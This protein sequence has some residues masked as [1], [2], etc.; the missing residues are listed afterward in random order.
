MDTAALNDAAAIIAATA[1]F[2]AKPSRPDLAQD[3]VQHCARTLRL[4][5]VHLASLLPDQARMQ[6]QAAWMDGKPAAN[7]SYDLAGTPAADLARGAHHCIQSGAQRLFPTDLQLRLLGAQGYVGAPVATPA[8]QIVGVLVGTTRAPLR[9]PEVVLASL[10]IFAQ[11]AGAERA[12]REARRSLA[13]QQDRLRSVLQRLELILVGV[14]DKGRINLINRQ[15]CDLLG[16]SES[17]LIGQDWRDF[18]SP[19]PARRPERCGHQ[20]PDL[21]GSPTDRPDVSPAGSDLFVQSIHT[22]VRGA[23]LIAW[24]RDGLEDEAGRSVG[25]LYI[26]EDITERRSAPCKLTD[27]ALL[28]GALADSGPALIWAAD[29][30]KRCH[31]FN[32]VWLAFTGRTLEQERGFGWT[33]GVHPDDLER[34]VAAYSAAF[35]RREAF[36]LLYRLRRHDG[37]YR[38]LQ[39]DGCP[40]YDQTG[41]LIGYIG[42]CLDVTAAQEAREAS[43]SERRFQQAL[44]DHFPFMIWLKDKDGR[45]LAVNETFAKIAQAP[46]VSWMLGKTDLDIWPEPLAERYRADD[47][48][49]LASREKLQVEE[50]IIQPDGPQ[51]FETFKAPVANAD[52]TL[53]GTIGF[54]RNV[55][56]RKAAEERIRQ[57]AYFD[58]LTGLPNRRLLMDRLQHALVASNRSRSYG[59]LLMLDL[60]HFKALND[61]RGHDVGDRLLSEVAHRIKTTLREEDT[62]S[63]L[64]GDEYVVMLEDLGASET[65]AANEAELIADKVR[66]AINA[67][68][69]L[70]DS[71][72]LH[73][74]TSS[75]GLTLFRGAQDPVEVLLKQADVALYQAKDAGR[76]AVRFFNPAMQTA[77]ESRIA[78]EAELR[79]A[80]GGGELRLFYQPQ[81]NREG[82]CFGAEALLRWHRP[83]IGLVPPREFVPLA[84]ETGLILSIGRWVLETACAQLKTWSA[85]PRTTG[86]QLAINVSAR[87]FHQADFVAQVRDCIER[88]G[89]NPER[90]RLELTETTILGHADTVIARMHELKALGIGFSMDDFGNGYSSLSSLKRLP[91]DQLKIDQSFVRDLTTD[92]SDAAIVK[93]ILA[94]SQSLGL[95]TIAEGVETGEQKRFLE[96]HGCYAFQGH[97]FGRPVPIEEWTTE[98]GSLGQD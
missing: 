59:A 71:G 42:Y 75:I 24:R 1:A 21:T 13:Q 17:E 7:W 9:A 11:R 50:Q 31:Y 91:L 29:R 19:S 14:D 70:A 35:D 67:P 77:I 76:N 53:L 10:R 60:D 94:M 82:R 65:T 40:R 83:R 96:E 41:A 73:H 26:G 79:E 4:D 38:W 56:D 84:E 58:P 43:L 12:E 45:F 8:G 88:A 33:E 66:T 37:E 69:D 30:D 6:T 52:G 46:S 81:M 80:V 3:L 47:A 55:S 68:Y 74:C 72:R 87:Q 20:T 54:S 86:L 93:A 25:A 2:V 57:L 92:P 22:G 85:D 32:R 34:C 90:L 16:R 36:S 39:D 97:L 44:F 95:Q 61:T 62:V 15:G 18:F 23:R 48:R 64:G 51:W 49:V 28:C 63:R 5:Q 89:A 98:P 27:D 78:L